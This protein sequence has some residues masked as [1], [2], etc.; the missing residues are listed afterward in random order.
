MLALIS[1]AMKIYKTKTEKLTGSD[2]KEVRQKAWHCYQ[3]IKKRSRR[4][5]Y[6]RSAYFKKEKIFIDLFWQHIFE[7]ENWRDR[8]RRLKCF[9]AGIELVQKSTLEPSTKE[10]P[11]KSSEILHRFKGITPEKEVFYVQIKENKKTSQKF[12]MSI[13]PD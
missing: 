12:L 13:F 6:V 3:I 4:R 10:N 8:V 2:L 9:P 7:K 1:Y 5:A 11:N